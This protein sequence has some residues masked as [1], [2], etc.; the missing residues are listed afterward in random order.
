MWVLALSNHTGYHLL[1]IYYSENHQSNSI[2]VFHLF[3]SGYFLSLFLWH[4]NT[5]GNF[6]IGQARLIAILNGRW[7]FFILPCF[8]LESQIS[9]VNDFLILFVTLLSGFP[10]IMPA[11]NATYIRNIKNQSI[12]RLES[13]LSINAF[14]ELQCFIFHVHPVQTD[15]IFHI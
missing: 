2:F 4:I 11:N 9:I 15:I 5:V 7:R 14:D 8:I 13:I 6:R 10:M 12:L 1:N 3:C